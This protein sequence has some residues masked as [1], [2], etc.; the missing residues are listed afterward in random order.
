MIITNDKQQNSGRCRT[1]GLVMGDIKNRETRVKIAKETLEII[2]SGS[3]I[4]SDGENI[5]LKDKLE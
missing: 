2:S 1:G 5:I 3:Y 4:N